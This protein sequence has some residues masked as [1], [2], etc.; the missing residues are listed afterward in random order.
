MVLSKQDA[1]LVAAIQSGLPLVEHPYAEVGQQIGLTESEVI[2]R[3]TEMRESGI[4]KRL[5]VV[6]RH[7]ELGYVAN[8]MVVWDVPTERLNLVGKLL[9]SQPC[10][11]LCYE[12]PRKLPEWPYN[13]FSMIHGFSRERVLSRISKMVAELGLEDIDYQVLFSGRRFKQRGARYQ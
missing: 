9:G 13:L 1:Q 8:A 12:R 2:E 6:V 5:G 4:I 3:I 11:T 7:H 10:V